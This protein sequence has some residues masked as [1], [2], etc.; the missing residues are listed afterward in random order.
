MN[1]DVETS[2]IELRPIDDL[3]VREQVFN[4]LKDHIVS[5]EIS[6]GTRL[7]EQGL[8]ASLGVSRGPL[9]EA[10]RELV[11]IGLI[12]SIPYKGISVRSITRK[13]LEEL[14]SLRTTLE[15]FAFRLCWERR[16]PETL[17]DLRR[18]NAALVATVDDG[19][20][21]A[22]AI[23]QE[24]HLHSWCY[25]LSDHS[26]LL[27][28]WRRI[29]PSLKFYFS[30][31]QLAHSRSGPLRQAHDVYVS[32]AEG[33]SLDA[34]LEHLATHMRQGFDVTASLLREDA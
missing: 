12:V 18:R 3:T 20:D 1:T 7:T 28:S 9:R 29:E 5:G 26:L 19:A 31:H 15:S 16:T 30:L 21:P 11:D 34:M 2:S 25:E 22:L 6:P 10:I 17:D 4:R 27:K 32:L 13:D 23:D 14:Y 33:P 24:L 8:A